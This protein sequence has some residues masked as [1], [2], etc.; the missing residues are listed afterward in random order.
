MDHRA[1]SGED[2]LWLLTTVQRN[3]LHQLAAF[4]NDIVADG[5]D[6]FG[7]DVIVAVRQIGEAEV[8]LRVTMG[9][10]KA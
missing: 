2:D 1:S 6:H 10:A 9:S 4:R 3:L 5:P 7:D 8:A